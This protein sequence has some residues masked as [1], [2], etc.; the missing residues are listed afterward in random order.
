MIIGPPLPPFRSRPGR[1]PSKLS[2]D[3]LDRRIARIDA[4]LAG[5]G[6][7]VDFAGRLILSS[8]AFVAIVALACWMTPGWFAFLL[9]ALVMGVGLWAEVNP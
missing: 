4:Q 1:I 7:F 9:I 3:Y 6:R 8:Y 2:T 5:F